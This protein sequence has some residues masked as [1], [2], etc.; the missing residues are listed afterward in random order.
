MRPFWILDCRF[1]IR[2][3]NEYKQNFPFFSLS[4]APAIEN[5]KLEDSAERAG[6]GRSGDSVTGSRERLAVNRKKQEQEQ[7]L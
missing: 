2:E 4:L 3:E 6:A 5:P 7:W 1:R